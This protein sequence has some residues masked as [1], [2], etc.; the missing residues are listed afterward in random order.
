MT[1]ETNVL[2]E[3]TD[4]E[5]GELIEYVDNLLSTDTSKLDVESLRGNRIFSN[6]QKLKHIQDKKL[7]GLMQVKAE[8]EHK[9]WLHY[10]GKESGKHYKENPLP[11]AILKTDVEKYM[12]IDTKV[13]IVREAVKT[14]DAICLFIEE[15]LKQASRRSFDIKN[16]LAWQQMI[17]NR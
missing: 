7:R 16:A 5:L 3:R 17:N 15:A 1:Q 9:R 2:Y 6:L 8:C 10:S 12:A 11:E 4:I 13:V 14:Q